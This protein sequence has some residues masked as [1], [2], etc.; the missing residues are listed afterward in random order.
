[1]N[2]YR[3]IGNILPISQT[4]RAGVFRTGLWSQLSLTNRYQTPEDPRTLVDAALPNFHETFDT[5]SLQPYVEYELQPFARLK[6]TP[7]VKYSYYKQDFVQF[8]DNGKTVGNLNGA[9]SISH[10]AAY[11][12]WLPSFDVHYL[13][14]R[15]VSVYAQY[16][17]GDA[18]PPT[19][20]FDTKNAAVGVLPKPTVAV[21]YQGGTVL[22]ARRLSLGFDVFHTRFDNTYSSAL[23]R[24]TNLTDFFAS[25]PSI[26]RGVE[27]E[28]NV[29]VGGG[30]SAYINA[31]ALR[32]TFESNGQLVQNSPRHTEAI[33]VNFARRGATVS[34]FV[35]HAA[36][37]FND[38]STVHEAI[39]IAPVSIVNL[40]VGYG[41]KNRLGFSKQ[42]KIRFSVNNLLD[43][44]NIIG[45][46]PASK[47]SSLPNP[48]D[49][50]TL[51]SARSAALTFTFDLA[52]R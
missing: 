33:G 22:Q 26:S 45:V 4:S 34:L 6:I 40:S 25:G 31:T 23:N 29:A 43:K 24:E 52:K 39:T 8:A 5:T 32:A 38:N 2:A 7:G 44:H 48:N 46:S 41:V 47:T 3:T 16:A 28:T 21:T 17:K 20:V 1:L 37:M 10:A 35:K 18:I 27:F 51:L 30:L 49:Q 19:K 15:N 11:K 14:L 42:V 36:S 9:A 13:V 12:T 50:V